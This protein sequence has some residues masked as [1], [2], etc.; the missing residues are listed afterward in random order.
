M[1]GSSQH[2]QDNAG[3]RRGGAGQAVV[4][5]RGA[6]GNGLHFWSRQRFDT[7]TE[8]QVRLRACLLPRMMRARLGHAKWA[9]LRG[10][11]A[12]CRS[13]RRPDGS[14]G[15]LV[16]LLITGHMR[17]APPC[18]GLSPAMECFRQFDWLGS[19]RMGMN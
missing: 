1:A 3:A 6:C 11:V 16:S 12:Q 15:F 2:S 17:E 8:L 18:P 19:P 4:E 14:I 5:W 10:F 7:G 13:E 9:N